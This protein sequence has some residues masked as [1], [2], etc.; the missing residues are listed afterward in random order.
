MKLKAAECH[1]KLGEVGLE[2]E[3]YETS[4]RDFEKCLELQK[5]HLEAESRLIAET[6]YQ[7]G[8]ASC[9]AQTYDKSLKHLRSAVEVIRNKISKFYLLISL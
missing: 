5:E 3:Q 4:I 2:T 7:I 6:H 9:F 1:L 8:L